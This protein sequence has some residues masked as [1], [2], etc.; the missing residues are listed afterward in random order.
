MAFRH[1]PTWLY[2]LTF[3]GPILIGLLAGINAWSSASNDTSI[4][5]RLVVTLLTA[6]TPLIG[7]LVFMGLPTV[8]MIYAET[9]RRGNRMIVTG[10]EHEGKTV[11]VTRRHRLTE[12]GWVHVRLLDD[13][14]E[15]TISPYQLKKTG[16]WSHL[17]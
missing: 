1:P 7:I 12:N 6:V 9:P 2:W 4:L 11:V 8:A 15:T 3:G 10:G 17:L 13:E 14:L 16:V 5:T